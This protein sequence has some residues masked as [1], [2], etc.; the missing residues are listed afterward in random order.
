MGKLAGDRKTLHAPCPTDP[1]APKV[2]KKASKPEKVKVDPLGGL[3]E[4]E[5]AARR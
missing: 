5:I 4:V 2:I 3:F 1:E